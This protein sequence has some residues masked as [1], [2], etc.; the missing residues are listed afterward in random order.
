[1]DVIG[2]RKGVEEL[3]CASTAAEASDTRLLAVE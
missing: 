2:K 1:M 3:L